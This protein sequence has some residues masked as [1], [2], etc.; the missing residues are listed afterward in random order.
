ML[1]GTTTAT[2]SAS[3]LFA[4]AIAMFSHKRVMN[5]ATK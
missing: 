4:M 1:D 5:P 2:T 3:G